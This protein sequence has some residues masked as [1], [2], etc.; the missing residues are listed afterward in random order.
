MKS[1]Y[2]TVGI[3]IITP[4][5]KGQLHHK[6]QTVCTLS[7]AEHWAEAIE[8]KYATT[9]HTKSATGNNTLALVGALVDIKPLPRT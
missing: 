8:A 6:Q 2:H 7:L 3:P 1:L 9:S 4:M 5:Y